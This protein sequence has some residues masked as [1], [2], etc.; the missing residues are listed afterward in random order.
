MSQSSASPASV[1]PASPYDWQAAVE[2]YDYRQ[3]AN[4]I[5]PGLTEPIPVSIPLEVLLVAA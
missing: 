2:I 3:A 5:R 1:T 4:P